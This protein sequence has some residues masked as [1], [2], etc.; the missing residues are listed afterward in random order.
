[1]SKSSEMTLKNSTVLH[2]T[3][4]MY[5]RID[6]KA[7]SRDKEVRRDLEDT[8]VTSGSFKFIRSSNYLQDQPKFQIVAGSEER[9]GG[10]RAMD[11]E[12]QLFS[13]GCAL[14]W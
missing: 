11:P 6:A 2:A 14:D 7:A 13:M 9:S 1:M 10:H 4:L 5:R 8:K 12:W 3:H